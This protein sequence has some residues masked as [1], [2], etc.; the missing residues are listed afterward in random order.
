[1]QFTPAI[2][3]THVEVLYTL[4]MGL[5][6]EDQILNPGVSFIGIDPS[7]GERTVGYAAIDHELQLTA[8]G[9]GKMKD[10]LAFAGGRHNAIVAVHAP[11]RLNQGVVRKMTGNQLD[12]RLGEEQMHQRELS[13][14]K[15]PS[16]MSECKRWMVKG[17]TLY[18]R[19]FELGYQF[20]KSGD[21]AKQIIEAAPEA[22]FQIWSQGKLLNK[23]SLEG[24]I[25]RQLLLYELGLDVSDPMHFFQEITRHRISMGMLPKEMIL[26]PA[27]LNALAGA[28]T[29]WMVVNQSENIELL[30]DAEE[31]QITLPRE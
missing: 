14:Y 12:M 8:I 1:V 23:R 18:Q 30:G 3:C 13:I 29:A 26:R 16:Q 9:Q 10:A 22:C 20:N 11:P 7:W 25:Q 17:F 6:L 19:L 24:R 27:E 31:G 21:S 4:T 15:T 2:N 28:Y 5:P